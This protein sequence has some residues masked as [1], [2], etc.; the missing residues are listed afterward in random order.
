[1]ITT[2]LLVQGALLLLSVGGLFQVQRFL[3]SNPSIISAEGFDNFKRLARV[4]MYVALVYI[5]LS[6]PALLIGIYITYTYGV[7][8]LVVVLAISVPQYL[9]GKY[10]KRV[11]DKSRSLECSTLYADEHRRIGE[12]WVKKALPDF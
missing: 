1:M 5:V 2:Y 3:R 11:E 7:F 6:V 9:L 4:N 8:G 10:M 12:T